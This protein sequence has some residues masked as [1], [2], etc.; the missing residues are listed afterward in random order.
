[1]DQTELHAILAISLM[2]AFA[3]GGKDEREREQIKRIAEGLSPEAEADLAKLYQDV[4]L[5]SRTLEDSARSLSSPETRQLAYEMAVG[6]CDADDRRDAAETDFLERLRAALGLDAQPARDFAESADGLAD[7][8]LT[9]TPAAG[10]D[11]AAL[12]ASVLNYAILNGALELL[13]QS[14]ASMAIL[15]LQ[16]K[17]VYAIGKAHGYELDRVHI[18]D[19]AAT[20]G[21]GMTGQYLEQMGRKLLGGL[22]GKAGG[23]LLGSLG[24]AA[25]GAAFSFAATYAF[26]KVAQHYYGNGRRIDTAEL[27]QT[28]AR[29][30]AQGKELQGR[31]AGEIA[32][33]ARTLDVPQVLDMVKRR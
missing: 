15:P 21:V 31:Y 2:A 5:K 28:F 10:P 27:K 17:M 14:M 6:V 7:A 3:D 16:M 9:A 1:M 12:D 18:T 32:H 26:G 23:G 30:F 25:T 8:P 11:A 22:L 13:P 19:F 29:L 4:L 20:L 33:K 24:G